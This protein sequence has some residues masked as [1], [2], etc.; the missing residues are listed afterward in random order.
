MNAM[1]LEFGVH[2]FK[3]YCFFHSNKT[4]LLTNALKTLNGKTNNLNT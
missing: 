2:V 3:Y 4:E 1:F